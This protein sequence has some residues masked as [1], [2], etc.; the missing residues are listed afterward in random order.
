MRKRPL[1]CLLF[2]SVLCILLP[3]S[4]SLFYMRLLF[5]CSIFCDLLDLT[6]LLGI[7]L[8]L[9]RRVS[10]LHLIQFCRFFFVLVFDDTIASIDSLTIFVRCAYSTCSLSLGVSS[11][12]L[13]TA[14]CDASYRFCFD[15]S[16]LIRRS[17]S[18]AVQRCSSMAS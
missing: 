4:C 15:L 10:L 17:Q 7:V 9:L 5:S 11:R 12:V 3:R 1:S 14:D 16:I 13:Q 2:L 18:K 8:F 6:C